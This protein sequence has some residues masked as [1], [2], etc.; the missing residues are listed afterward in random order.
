MKRT[1]LLMFAFVITSTLFLYGCKKEVRIERNLWKSGGEWNIESLV[2]KQTSTNSVDNFNETIYNYGTL[3]F[4]KDNSGSYKFTVDGDVET[5]S[6][7]YFNTEDKLTLV[8]GNEA[9]VFDLDWERN[10]I[11]MS[12]TENYTDNGAS[13]TYTE[14]YTLKKK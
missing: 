6:F 3:T 10:N 7:T 8:V 5:G 14:T 1:N 4:K 11:V 13:I 2:A 12:I 9:R